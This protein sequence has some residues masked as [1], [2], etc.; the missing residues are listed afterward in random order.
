MFCPICMTNMVRDGISGN[1]YCPN[2]SYH[3]F[4][5]RK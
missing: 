5:P 2:F 3:T 4:G 1:W